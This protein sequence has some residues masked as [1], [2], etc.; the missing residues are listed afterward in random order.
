[1]EEKITIEKF[2]DKN[3]FYIFFKRIIDILISIMAVVFLLFILVVLVPL[4]MFGENKGR[5]FFKQKRLGKNGRTFYIYKFRTM[6]IGAEEKL[7]HNTIL[8][9]KY[10]ENNYKLEP[11]EDPR[12][13]KMG[14]FLRSTSIDEFPQ[15]I[16]VLKGEMS[17]I[18]PRPVVEEELKEYKQL[19]SKFLSVKPGITGYWQA[20]GRSNIGYPERVDIELYYIDNKSIWLDIKI[21]MQTVKIVFLRKGA[22]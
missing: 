4:Y 19:K 11:D 2:R 10:I 1:M 15:F 3:I 6:V 21:F 7:K 16:N 13:T 5:I 17:L 8:Y 12:I 18:G 14:A 22:Y 9:Q 20:S